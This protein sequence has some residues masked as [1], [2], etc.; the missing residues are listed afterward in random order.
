MVSPSEIRVGG[1]PVDKDT[2]AIFDELHRVYR[3]QRE[4]SRPWDFI[5][6]LIIRIQ[7]Q[8]FGDERQ[9]ALMIE[10][11]SEKLER[12]QEQRKRD[13]ENDHAVRYIDWEPR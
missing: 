8:D 11:L 3:I 7:K 1:V 2:Q 9:I 10:L 12:M 13:P 4:E 6:Q 5:S